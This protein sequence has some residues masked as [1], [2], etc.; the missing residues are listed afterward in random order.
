MAEAKR[1][2]NSVTT[3]LA[4]SNVD[5]IT[6]VV[7]YA[8]PTTHRLLVSASA[9]SLNDLTDVIITAGAQGDVLYFDGT[10][11]RN[12]GAGASGKFLRTNGAGANP[13]WE[14]ATATITGTDTHVLF[15]DG[16]N[17]PAGEAGFTY[18]KT[19]DSATLAGAVTVG[20]GVLIGVNDAGALG[21]SGTAFSD[22]FLASGAVINFAA[23]NV[24]ITHS[25]G[26]LTL[27]ASMDLRLTTAGTNAASV[28]LVGGTQTLTNKTLTSPVINTGTVGTS[29]NP[30]SDDGATL[31]DTT[32]NYSD[33]FL[34]TGALI[35]YAN[36]NVVVTHSSGILTVSTGDLRVTTAGTN[37]A[38]VVTVGGTQTLTNKTLTSPTLTSP[39]LGTPASGVMTNVTGVPSFVVA[40]EGTDT[41]CFPLFV[42]AATGELGPKTNANLT[43]NSNTGALSIG[44]SAPFT[45]GTIELGA[46]SDT[47]IA[48]S[49]AG[50]ISVEG[51]QVVTLSNSVT[52][53]SKTI[54]SGIFTGA[55]V[56]SEGASIQL[57]PAG[58]A[59]GA[60]SGITMTAVAGYAQTYGDLV[61]L[62]SVDSR[63]EL[64]DADAA[65]TA[66][67][68]LAMVVVAGGSD[69]AS[70]TLLLM[71][72]IRAD[73][74]FPSLTIGSA[75]YVGETPGAIQ[76]AIPTGADSVIRRVG[77]AL[78][79]DEIYFN[80]S[81]DSQIT[82][83]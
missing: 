9:G 28:V 54:A 47:T 49:A 37:A 53:T 29:L 74:K 31:G 22:L 64:A 69:G 58:S 68:M 3:L 42:T 18:N 51:V 21:A 33:L 46:A 40:N 61:Y 57:D 32:H 80:P 55:N 7:L 10:D 41:T 65:S 77:Y 71:G 56:L 36:G 15:F 26:V 27:G 35:N 39:A 2:G 14:T 75:V 73:A 79:A 43:Y 6:P 59:D 45:A 78:T 1:D 17:N 11:W 8:D 25:A 72:T 50:Q 66:D 48:R 44:T 4:V 13:S 70:C 20:T 62:S 67:R 12:L 82:V 60:Y 52:L 30:T 5:G 24:T 81:M 83:A 16:N 63:W 23:G 38:S 34:A 19:T 76:V